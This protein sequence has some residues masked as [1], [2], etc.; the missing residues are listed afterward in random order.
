MA[1]VPYLQL[2]VIHGDYATICWGS[3]Y[4]QPQAMSDPLV[5]DGPPLEVPQD[6]RAVFG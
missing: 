2:V 6:N 4:M 1:Y 5:S 3:C